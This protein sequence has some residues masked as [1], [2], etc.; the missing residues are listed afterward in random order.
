MI[1]GFV[2]Y[3]IYQ[4]ASKIFRRQTVMPVKKGFF[5]GQWYVSDGL[6]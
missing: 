3:V 4:A 2:I 6:G 1:R 5:I